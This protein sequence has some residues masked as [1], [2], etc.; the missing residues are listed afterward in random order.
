MAIEKSGDSVKVI[1]L[2]AENISRIICGEPCVHSMLHFDD[3]A[4]LNVPSS[5]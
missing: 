3:M 5:R 2:D 4:C 1:A